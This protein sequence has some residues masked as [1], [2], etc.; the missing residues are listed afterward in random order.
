M[1]TFRDNLATLTL[2]SAGV[3]MILTN[4]SIS[5]TGHSFLG[6]ISQTPH[7]GANSVSAHQ[8]NLTT[9]PAKLLTEGVALAK[10]LGDRFIPLLIYSLNG[11]KEY[12]LH[13]VGRTNHDSVIQSLKIPQ[14]NSAVILIMECWFVWCAFDIGETHRK[15]RI[16]SG[17]RAG[18]M[19]I[20]SGLNVMMLG[21][22]V[23]IFFARNK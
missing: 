8:Q 13:Q 4:R 22:R 16:Q 1:T 3:A 20:G 6:G 11:Q 17:D 7:N 15:G 12:A 10:E 21:V 2:G 18:L 14:Q 9:D 23:V 19:G 5:T